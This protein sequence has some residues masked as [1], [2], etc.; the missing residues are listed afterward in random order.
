M[1]A[2]SAGRRVVTALM[3]VAAVAVGVG[4]A[5]GQDLSS[6]RDGEALG[7]GYSRPAR[8]PHSSRSEVIAPYGMVAASQPLAAAATMPQPPNG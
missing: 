5:A 7:H 6:D 3:G 8:S 4:T 1:L 2:R